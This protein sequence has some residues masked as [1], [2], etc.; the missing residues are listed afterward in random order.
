MTLCLW[1]L[2]RGTQGAAW[3]YIPQGRKI[4]SWGSYCFRRDG[5]FQRLI[6]EW[7]YL[8][9]GCTRPG[10]Q[11]PVC[12]PRPPGHAP[13]LC[14]L[15]FPRVT[16]ASLRCAEGSGARFPPGAHKAG[17]AGRLL[18]PRRGAPSGALCTSSAGLISAS[19]FTA[20]EV[21]VTSENCESQ[22]AW[23][24]MPRKGHVAGSSRLWGF[25]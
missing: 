25:E 7:G 16:A 18:L 9:R 8:S 14:Q 24:A 15:R 22:R 3:W 6:T 21:W 1:L 12:P 23:P 17:R 11:G 13:S 5:R 2:G 19:V 20:G 4:A 10:S